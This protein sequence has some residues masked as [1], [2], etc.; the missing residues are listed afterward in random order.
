MVKTGK[1][2]TGL[3]VQGTAKFGKLL[4]EEAK[5]KNQEGLKAKVVGEIQRK[6]DHIERQRAFITQAESTLEVLEAQLKALETGQ[7]TLE[8]S[9]AIKFTDKEL[10][11]QLASAVRCQQCGYEKI[12][13]GSN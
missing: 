8:K 12:V 13:I 9:G 2:E 11:A 5:Q 7:F 4:I 1:P 6:L 10:H 3:V